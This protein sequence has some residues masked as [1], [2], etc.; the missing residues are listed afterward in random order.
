MRDKEAK[1]SG[2]KSNVAMLRTVQEGTRKLFQWVDEICELIKSA[3]SKRQS[4]KITGKQ[5]RNY[6]LVETILQGAVQRKD[7]SRL[8]QQ[9]TTKNTWRISS[10]KKWKQL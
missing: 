1:K 4:G 10:E 7:P 2:W 5:I 3:N 6:K 8:C 9:V